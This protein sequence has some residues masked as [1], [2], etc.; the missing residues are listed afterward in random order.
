MKMTLDEFKTCY[1]ELTKLPE[2]KVK[3]I[4]IMNGVDG[5]YLQNNPVKNAHQALALNFP[6]QDRIAAD[7]LTEAMEK[8]KE[9]IGRRAHYT[10]DTSDLYDEND[11]EGSMIMAQEHWD[12]VLSELQK[13]VSATKRS[14]KEWVIRF[15]NVGWRRQTG[16]TTVSADSVGQLF[17]KIF[18][19]TE[20]SISVWKSDPRKD[21]E[22]YHF[23]VK[24]FH[25][26]APT[27]ESYFIYKPTLKQYNEIRSGKALK[28]VLE[29]KKE[30]TR[31]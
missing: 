12:Y 30:G 20:Y 5:Y 13:H 2:D 9:T 16:V 7:L 6:K 27:G 14:N 23:H 8:G 1:E 10:W 28:T 29:Q 3:N 11:P 21:N 15:V 26:D 19:N 4:L 25:H 18:P 22:W 24:L 17:G 31:K